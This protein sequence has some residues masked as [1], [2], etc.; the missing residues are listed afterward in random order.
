MFRSI[1]GRVET[2]DAAGHLPMREITASHDVPHLTLP[3]VIPRVEQLQ[4]I[5]EELCLSAGREVKN[6]TDK[7]FDR[8]EEAVIVGLITRHDADM[9]WQAERGTVADE[10]LVVQERVA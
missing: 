3:Q 5:V 8:L 9:G 2:S 7:S 6:S 10:D 4:G 1:L